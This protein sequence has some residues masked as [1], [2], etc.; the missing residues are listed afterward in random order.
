MV[1]VGGKNSV[2]PCGMD[3]WRGWAMREL[4]SANV[5]HRPRVSVGRPTQGHSMSILRRPRPKWSL[6]PV[7][8]ITTSQDCRDG[9]IPLR[10]FLALE[11]SY[12]FTSL[13]VEHLSFHSVMICL[14]SCLDSLCTLSSLRPSSSAK[15]EWS[16][17]SNSNASWPLSNPSAPWKHCHLNAIERHALWF[18][19]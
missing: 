12:L 15:A 9:R 14:F 13:N 11:T 5:S 16:Q 8:T 7:H 1:C 3:S 4:H 2:S 10:K 17:V 19:W 6:E 18:W